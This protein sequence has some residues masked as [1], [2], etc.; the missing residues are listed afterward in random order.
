ML[1]RLATS[2]LSKLPCQ[3]YPGTGAPPTPPMLPRLLRKLRDKGTRGEGI[4]PAMEHLSSQFVDV[5]ISRCMQVAKHRVGFPTP[6]KA[7][8]I[9]IDTRAKEGC[10]PTCSQGAGFHIFRGDVKFDARCCEHHDG[11]SNGFCDVAGG[12]MTYMAIRVSV[13]AQGSCRMY[14]QASEVVN[15]SGCS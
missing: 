8:E 15:T 2:L 5:R 4:V 12:N 13:L 11:G 6:K 10:G 1:G 14:S 7:Y 9:H 3:T